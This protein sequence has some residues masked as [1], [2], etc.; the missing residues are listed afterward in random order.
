MGSS[1]L[2]RTPLSFKASPW[3]HWESQLVYSTLRP[4]AEL[5]TISLQFSRPLFVTPRMPD[6]QIRVISTTV[7]PKK[8]VHPNISNL[9]LEHQNKVLPWKLLHIRLLQSSKYLKTPNEGI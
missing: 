5:D 1:E 4:S 6:T 8:K 2:P 3:T 9:G 7:D